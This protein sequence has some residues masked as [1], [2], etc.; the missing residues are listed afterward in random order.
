M[1]LLRGRKESLGTRL[2]FYIWPAPPRTLTV[3]NTE[4]IAVDRGKLLD[5]R[6]NTEKHG[7]TLG[8]KHR[9]DT[10]S[11]FCRSLLVY[12]ENEGFLTNILY[13]IIRAT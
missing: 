4:S 8:V 13:K 11:L 9:A 7:K 1:E 3:S 2:P 5:S 10:F 12:T 6:T